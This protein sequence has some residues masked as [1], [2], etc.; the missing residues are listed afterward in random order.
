ML[1]SSHLTKKKR[2]LI[3]IKPSEICQHFAD[4]VVEESYFL[5]MNSVI[6]VAVMTS[7]AWLVFKKT[8]LNYE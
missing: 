3:F 1:F 8:F 6:S 4:F 7:E 2:S 5:V